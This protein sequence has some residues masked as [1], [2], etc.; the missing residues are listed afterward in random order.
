MRW[1]SVH[2]G[3]PKC[4]RDFIAIEFIIA[5]ERIQWVRNGDRGNK[6]MVDDTMRLAHFFFDTYS[7]GIRFE[8]EVVF[9]SSNGTPTD[10]SM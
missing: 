8:F 7:S 5:L 10:P 2:F 9:I 3:L 1:N 4:L 6:S